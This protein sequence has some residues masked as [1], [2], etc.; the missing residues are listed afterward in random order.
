[1]AVEFTPVETR[2]TFEEAVEQIADRITLGELKLGD[3]LPSE[4]DLALQMQISRPTVREALRVLADSGV[5]EIKPGARGGAFV[6]SDVVP[7]DVLRHRSDMRVSEVRGVIEARRLLEPQVAQLAAR[8]ARDSDYEVMQRTIERMVELSRDGAVLDHED[9]F[10]ALDFQFHLAIAQA[11]GNST[12]VGLMRSLLRRLELARDMAVHEPLVADWTIEIHM[13]TVRAIRGG[14]EEEIRAVM[15]AH[16]GRMEE[17]WR[18]ARD[19]PA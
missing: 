13:R 12:I 14:D 1:M 5:V 8:N 9:R 17:S 15:D 3:Q 19:R 4:R 18:W 2:R 16:L 6:R 11:T 10:L 7:R